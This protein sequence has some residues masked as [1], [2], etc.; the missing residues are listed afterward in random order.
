[1]WFF[2]VL[3]RSTSSSL[4]FE[5]ALYKER[6]SAWKAS[7]C[8]LTLPFLYST[9]LYQLHNFLL[10]AVQTQRARRAH[11]QLPNRCVR[12]PNRMLLQV[13]TTA[14]M[15]QMTYTSCDQ[16]IPNRNESFGSIRPTQRCNEEATYTSR[17]AP[18]GLM[19][20]IQLL[21][22]DNAVCIEGEISYLQNH[23]KDFLLSR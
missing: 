9:M 6:Y 12:D 17:P 15:H 4:K 21:F 13:Q 1:M 7:K 18:T 22:L 10:R 19:T 11:L 5:W 2:C 14:L 3:L 20:A 23:S 8:S 16:T